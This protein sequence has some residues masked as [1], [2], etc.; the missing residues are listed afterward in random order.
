[1]TMFAPSCASASTIDLPMPVLP[2]VTIATLPCSVMQSSSS[3]LDSR[4]S[5]GIERHPE[6]MNRGRPTTTTESPPSATATTAVSP[7]SVGSEIP[8]AWSG[9]APNAAMP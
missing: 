2:P 6:R 1:M 5:P 9:P 7:N 3:R 4:I 8:A